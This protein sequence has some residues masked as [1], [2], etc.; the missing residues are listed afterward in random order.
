MA[1]AATT[2]WDV[3][4]TGNAAN[5]GGFN[6]A[7]AG[8][9]YSQ[10]DSPQVTY[11]DLVIDG[12]TNTKLTSAA[13]PFTSAHVGNIINI[14]SGTGFTVQRV[15]I[16]SVTSGAATCDKSCGTLGSTGGNGRLGGSLTTIA[17]A[18][19]LCV[20]SNSIHI[21]SGTYTVTSAIDN[22]TGGIWIK[23]VGYGTTHLDRGTRPIITTAT[24]SVNLFQ[25]GSS[26]NRM[27]RLKFTSTAGV[28]FA[29]VSLQ[30]S[31]SAVEIVDCINDGCNQLLYSTSS[32]R[33]SFVVNCESTNG[34]NAVNLK[35]NIHVIGCYFHDNSGNAIEAT[36]NNNQIISAFV[37]QSIIADNG[38]GVVAPTN[39][40]VV[41]EQ[42]TITGQT[43]NGVTLTAPI[44]LTLVNNII[45][46]N[47][48]YGVSCSVEPPV[49][50]QYSN[51]F[52][53]NTS[54]NRNNFT[55]DS[56]DVTLTADPF[57]NAAGGDYSLNATAGG[58]A[59]C[60]DA[61]TQW[62]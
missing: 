41:I 34:A 20:S 2:E 62:S 43:G 14:T 13:N 33:P 7:S 31:D 16:V 24:N 56:T 10:Q 19:A 49:Y 21:K 4:T 29:A 46:D 3:R 35:N 30:N 59:A 22:G 60:R 9:D 12:V 52:G 39:A 25:L 51:A 61:G 5:G 26:K 37:S 27:E 50:A 6:T 36:T 44:S 42:C 47:G 53:S 40:N 58:G 23:F 32:D 48:G 17:A 28:R 45:Y 57:T 1:F 54:G 11:T 38:A 55:S 8:T 18:V 15:Q